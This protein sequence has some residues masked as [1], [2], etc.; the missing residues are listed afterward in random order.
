MIKTQVYLT[1]DQS[2]GVKSFSLRSGIRQSETIRRA[3]DHFLAHDEKDWKATLKSAN[4]IWKDRKKVLSD[5]ENIRSE[6]DRKN[7]N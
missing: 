1:P 3:L 4:G 7:K 6:F 2:R 5:F